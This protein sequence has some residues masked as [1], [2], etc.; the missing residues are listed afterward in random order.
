MSLL[1]DQQQLF[2]VGERVIRP[3]D[4]SRT[5]FRRGVV[6]GVSTIRAGIGVNGRVWYTYSVLWDE[7]T[8]PD[9]GYFGSGMEKEPLCLIPPRLL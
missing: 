1:Q 3:I 4:L 6:V 5:F 7:A 9:A 2:Q 8:K